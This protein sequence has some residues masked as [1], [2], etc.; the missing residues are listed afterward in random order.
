MPDF[1][2]F[3]QDKME[4]RKPCGSA[5]QLRRNWVVAVTGPVNFLG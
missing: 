3:N 5:G 2:S 1:G 4:P